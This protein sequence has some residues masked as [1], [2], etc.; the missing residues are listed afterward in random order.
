[1]L[2]NG[3]LEPTAKVDHFAVDGTWTFHRIILEQILT[4]ALIQLGE[5]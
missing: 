5:R 3:N 1:M 4:W 2:C